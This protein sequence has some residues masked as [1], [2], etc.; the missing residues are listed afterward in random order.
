MMSQRIAIFGGT[1][2]PPHMGHVAAARACV[3]ALALDKLLMIPTNIPPHKTLPDGSASP[4]QRLEM[5]AIAASMVP[6]AEVSD[7][8]IKR[9][10]ASYTADTV[11]QIKA[12]YPQSRLWL[13]V[14]TDMLGSFESWRRPGEIAAVCRLAAVARGHADRD[15]IIAQARRLEK[16]LDAHVDIVYNRVIEGSSTDFRLGRAH[17]LVPSEIRR[18]ITQNGL[19]GGVH[20]RI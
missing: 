5:T 6:M 2:N 16:S 12:V 1:F 9:Q 15:F 7:I 14:G 4:A 8:E 11:A 17:G 13:V 10:G 3:E 18:Y 20:D 19:Y